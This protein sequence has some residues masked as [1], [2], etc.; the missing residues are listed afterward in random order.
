MIKNI[1]EKIKEFDEMTKKYPSVKEF[2]IERAKLYCEIKEY[3]KA[4]ED[5]K[6]IRRLL[7]LP[8]YSNGMRRKRF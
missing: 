3:E 4:V 1:E 6:N 2:H 5:F 7:C 8:K